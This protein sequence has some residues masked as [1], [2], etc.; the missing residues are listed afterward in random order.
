MVYKQNYL[1][2]ILFTVSQTIINIQSHYFTKT[3]YQMFLKDINDPQTDRKTCKRSGKCLQELLMART[4]CI[5]RSA[6]VM[7]HKKAKLTKVI[8]MNSFWCQGSYQACS[9]K[10]SKMSFEAQGAK[11]SFSSKSYLFLSTKCVYIQMWFGIRLSCRMKLYIF[12]F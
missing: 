5:Y 3:F 10:S 12:I 11:D 7:S 8:I 9:S 2:T 4:K 6:C 1:T